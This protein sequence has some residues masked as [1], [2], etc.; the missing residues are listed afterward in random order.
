MLSRLRRVYY[1]WWVVGASVVLNA[2]AAGFY[3]LGSTVF[4]L[5][6]SRDLQISRTAASLPFT[7]SRLVA[8]SSYPVAGLAVDRWGSAGVLFLGALLAGLGYVLMHWAHSYALFL[9][10]FVIAVTPGVV[11]GF[12]TSPMLAISRWFV[13]RR[14]IAFATASIGFALGGAIITPLVAV[15]VNRQDWRTTALIVGVVIWAIGLPIST[16]F[17]RS[18]AEDDPNFDRRPRDPLVRKDMRAQTRLAGAEAGS[19]DFTVGSA[20]RTP[21]YWF[22]ALSYGL[23]GLVW[24]VLA[25]HLVAI[26]VWKSLEEPTAGLLLGAYPLFWIPATL[27]TGW[28]AGRWP[29]QRIV[30]TSGLIAAMGL[31]LLALWSRVEVWQMLVVLALL[32]SN[33]GSWP[34]AWVMLSDHFGRKNFGVLRGILMSTVGILA[35]GGPVYSGWVFDTWQGYQWV[36]LP[37]AILLGGAGILNWLTPTTRSVGPTGTNDGP[38]QV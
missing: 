31:A 37:G 20:L 25:I 26:M 30:A 17:R 27:V 6:M 21:T 8:A 3:H 13:R 16:V 18:P 24:S 34:L 19:F 10:V 9:I 35:V 15:G 11:A 2:L 23:R 7:L 29:A 22:I 5:P 28:L 33:E 36:V 32:A 38:L 4:F 1:G 12:D 14:G